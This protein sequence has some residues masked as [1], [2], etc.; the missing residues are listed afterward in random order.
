MGGSFLSPRWSVS[1]AV[2][3]WSHLLLPSS[4]FSIFEQGYKTWQNLCLSHGFC[5]SAS[6][7]NQ[8]L[9]INLPLSE[10]VLEP[11]LNL[12]WNQFMRQNLFQ[13]LAQ[14]N[15]SA[16]LG[17]LLGA[18]LDAKRHIVDPKTL[19]N[20]S[21]DGPAWP[22]YVRSQTE[23]HSTSYAEVFGNYIVGS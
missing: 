3:P 10:N 5:M 15:S 7:Q 8:V 18:K 9:W 2:G 16:Y 12:F 14:I 6:S 11:V 22:W 23:R 1:K 21:Q 19:Q 17:Q 20:R 13:N 4:M